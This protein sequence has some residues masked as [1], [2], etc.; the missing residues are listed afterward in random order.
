MTIPDYQTLMRPLL[1]A[2]ERGATTIPA[3]LAELAT[4]FH[5][6][7]EDRAAL[8]PSGKQTVLSNRAHWAKQ[9]MVRAGLLDVSQRGHFVA[10]PRG[11]QAL[12]DH[13][14]RI[15][16][17]VLMRFPEFASWRERS[18]QGHRERNAD[19]D[20]VTVIQANDISTPTDRIADAYREIMDQLRAE[21]LARV[22]EASPAR[23]EQVILDLLVAMNY[24]GSL[25]EAGRRLGRSGDGGVDG[26][27]NQDPLG[28]E[29]V[30]I[31][32]KRY[33]QG[34]SV[35]RPAVQAFVGSLDGLRANKGIL[36]TTS[37]F[38]ADAR[39]YAEMTS[40]RIVLING[41]Q[42]ADLL[43]RSNIGVRGSDTYEIKKIDEDYFVEE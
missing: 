11:R 31:Q 13:P 2:A 25:E 39:R 18:A 40:K 24:G 20:A 7:E 4:E 27:I 37:E 16:N 1:R 30:Y 9:Y 23:F 26:V 33:Q 14:D 28:L 42:L 10:T 15:D 5:L 6:S 12:I 35:G 17:S 29:V 32:A 22:E 38:T 8:L 21:I 43:I 19:S 3:S 41:Q 36:V 34:N